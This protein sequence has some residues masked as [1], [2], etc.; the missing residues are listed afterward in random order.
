ML[1]TFLRNWGKIEMHNAYQFSRNQVFSVVSSDRTFSEKQISCKMLNSVFSFFKRKM[2][3]D[4]SVDTYSVH[5]L[6]TFYSETKKGNRLY[7]A[8]QYSTSYAY[9]S[10]TVLVSLNI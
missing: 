7:A 1:A 10:S 5:L 8:L 2:D 6:L 4:D 9:Q 3:I